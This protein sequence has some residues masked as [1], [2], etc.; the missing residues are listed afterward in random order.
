M[1]IE[2]TLATRFLREGRSQS[3]LILG[4]IAIGVAVIVFL[5]ALI[6]G[7]QANLIERTLGSQ[8]HIK[9][10]APLQRNHILPAAAGTTTLLL[11]PPRPQPLRSINNWQQLRDSLDRQADITAVSPLISGPAFVRRG[12]ALE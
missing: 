8:A 2:W 10:Q 3:L 5:S 7:L 4:G 9:L 6:A 11:E 12:D 1:W